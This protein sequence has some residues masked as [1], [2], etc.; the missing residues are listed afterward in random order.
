M[1]YIDSKLFN[2]TSSHD[3]AHIA[4]THG[5]VQSKFVCEILLKRAAELGLSASVSRPGLIGP[6]TLTGDTNLR[7][8]STYL[9]YSIFKLGLSPFS[10]TDSNL[11]TKISHIPVDYVARAILY[12][13]VLSE[14]S[15][16]LVPFHLASTIANNFSLQNIL[17]TMSETLNIQLTSISFQE[18][19]DYLATAA[20][21]DITLRAAALLFGNDS[22]T[23]KPD[24]QVST[25]QARTL[26]EPVGVTCPIT[27][28]QYY[29]NMSRFLHKKLVVKSEIL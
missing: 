22:V 13:S 2:E 3:T 20:K 8:W 6:H 5:Y 21:H 15:T 28:D 24:V 10:P 29:K 14:E 18:F 17:K 25:V 11:K 26:L 16:K 23:L 12:I 7:D 19:I 4:L 27:T 1:S 9:V